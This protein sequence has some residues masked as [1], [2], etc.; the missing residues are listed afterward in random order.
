MLKPRVARTNVRT[1]FLKY[2]TGGEEWLY[3]FFSMGTKIAFHVLEALEQPKRRNGDGEINTQDPLSHASKTG[4]E[5]LQLQHVVDDNIENRG[6]PNCM[7]FGFL[8]C[9]DHTL[10]RVT[11][12]IQFS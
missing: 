9:N 11:T 10:R 6:Y 12:T 5:T 1:A 3:A 8:C 4:R 2:P 7:S